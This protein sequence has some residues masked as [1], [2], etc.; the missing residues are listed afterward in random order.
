MVGLILGIPVVGMVVGT[1]DGMILGIIVRLVIGD[2]IALIGDIVGVGVV[3]M[4]VIGDH[5][6]GGLLIGDRVIIIPIIIT[7]IMFLL[8]NRIMLVQEH[9]LVVVL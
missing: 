6:T 5:L 7:T 9:L 8:I 3:S 2:I 4:Q 1:E